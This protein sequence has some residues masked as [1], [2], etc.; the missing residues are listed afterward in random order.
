MINPYDYQ[1]HAVEAVRASFAEG[2]KRVVV[3]APT[4]A[5]KSV[6]L[7][8]IAAACIRNGKRVLFVVHL[9]EIMV[10]FAER[11]KALKE[12]HVG[13]IAPG[14]NR[15][16]YAPLQ[17]I[18][19]QGAVRKTTP[20]PEADVVLYDEVQHLPAQTFKKL[21]DF[22]PDA[23]VVGTSATPCRSDDKPLKMFD[24]LIVAAKYSELI[25]AKKIVPAMVFQPAEHKGSDL[26]C[27][28]IEAYLKYGRGERGFCFVR[29]ID[30]AEDVARR[31]TASDV[32]AAAVHSKL[33][34]RERL[35]AVARLKSGELRILTSDAIL[36]EGVNV[37]EASVCI[38]A[39]AC[40]FVG[41]YMQKCGRVL[42]SA[43]GKKHAIVI[44]LVG[45][46]LQHGLPHIDREFTLD[47]KTFDLTKLPPLTV[48]AA[49]GLTQLAGRTQCEGCG[50]V[51]LQHERKRPVIYSE[52]LRAVFN[53]TETPLEAKVNEWLRLIDTS[54]TRGYSVDWAVSSYTATFGEKVPN[55]WLS[56]LPPERKRREFEQWKAYGESRGFKSGYAFAR[57]QACFG[58]PP[59]RA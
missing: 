4:G 11:A 26:A 5:G 35:S 13:I 29:G 54:L 7:L 43:P 53:W 19:I 51:F 47:G 31:F 17:I 9:S 32:P 40:H 21:L 25:Q 44:D 2:I 6:I 55:E 52:E 3:Q 37:P 27:D 50:F 33:G 34:R 20:L 49:C 36:T 42:R 8:M 38:L 12:F 15:S 41:G 16:P 46:S 30:T 10:D 14:F 18:S 57:Y 45:S 56:A 59:P 23:F 58:A 28:P 48:C 1:T 39:S 22:Y 24:R